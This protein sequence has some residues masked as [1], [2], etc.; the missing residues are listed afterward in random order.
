MPEIKKYGVQ[1]LVVLEGGFQLCQPV[2]WIMNN[3]T[4]PQIFFFSSKHSCTKR[5]ILTLVI[6]PW[7]CTTPGM[8][9]MAWRSTATTLASSPPAVLPLQHKDDSSFNPFAPTKSAIILKILLSIHVLWLLCTV[10]TTI[11]NKSDAK[12]W[13]TLDCLDK[14]S[15]R[16]WNS[17]DYEAV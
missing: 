2:S 9:A 7:I 15:C 1:N 13:N 8:G 3:T 17:Q 16:L 6:S 14:Y 10:S 12:H 11:E 4:S 5:V